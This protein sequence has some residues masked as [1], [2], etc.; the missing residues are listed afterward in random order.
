MKFSIGVGFAFF[1]F[2]VSAFSPT[3]A[4]EVQDDAGRIIQLSRPATRIISL[5]PD[6]TELLFAVGAGHQIVGV[7]RGS[8]FP[9]EAR[10]LPVVA[11]Y[12]SLNEEAILALHPDLIVVWLGNSAVQRER[13]SRGTVPVFFSHQRDLSDVPKTMR[14]LGCLAGTQKDA[15]LAAAHFSKQLAKLRQQ[16]HDQRKLSV[17]YQVSSRPLMTINHESWINQVITLCGGQNIFADVK[18]VAPVINREALIL[19]DPDVIMGADVSEWRAWPILRS[20]QNKHLFA[21]SPDLLERAGPRLLQG[22]A[23]VCRDLA[24]TRGNSM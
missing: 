24:T 3:I 22:V 7:V 16:Y 14:K 21:V 15:N 10:A 23:K 1:F 19:A 4:C 6:L 5:A 11:T 12:N 13:L 9:D 17:F 2:C 20:V 8:D 18:A